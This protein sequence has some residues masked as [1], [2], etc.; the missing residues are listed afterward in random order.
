MKIFYVLVCRQCGDPD[1]P[2]PMPFGT[3]D[4]RGQWASE[5]TKA[6][7][8]DQWLVLDQQAPEEPAQ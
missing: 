8:H 4:E 5:H 6:T 7:G 3:Q 2:L 1:R